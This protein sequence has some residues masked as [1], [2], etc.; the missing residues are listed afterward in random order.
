M[1]DTTTGCRAIVAAIDREPDKATVPMWPWRPL[2]AA[3]AVLPLRLV[4]RLM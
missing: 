4:R 3:M 2:G 1:V